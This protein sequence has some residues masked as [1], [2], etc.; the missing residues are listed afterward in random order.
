YS[1]ID[2]GTQFRVFLPAVKLGELPALERAQ[3]DMPTGNGEVILVVDDELAIREI[4]KATLE[5]YGYRVL[6]ASDG[7][8]AIALYAQNKDLIQVVL[9][10]MMMPY[11]DGAATIRALQKIDPQVR[12]IASS[13][14]SENG[15]I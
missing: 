14:L 10:D 2:R 6:T 11:L 9:T 7:T 4:T 15:R 8:E 5:A 3:S 1:E 13:G 12:I